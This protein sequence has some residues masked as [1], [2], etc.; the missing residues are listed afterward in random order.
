MRVERKATRFLVARRAVN[1]KVFAVRKKRPP[2]Q[3]WPEISESA[4]V[5]ALP[6]P[7]ARTR[8][9][10]NVAIAFIQRFMVEG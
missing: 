6:G 2:P 4:Q 7:P 10:F 8:A 9:V 5:Q 3:G 1:E